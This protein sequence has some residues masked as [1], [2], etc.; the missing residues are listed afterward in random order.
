[1]SLVQVIGHANPTVWELGILT[2]ALLERCSIIPDGSGR[3]PLRR[4]RSVGWRDEM[5]PSCDKQHNSMRIKV[6]WVDLSKMAAHLKNK[7]T[8]QQENNQ[9]QGVVMQ[10]KAK[11]SSQGW[12]LFLIQNITKWFVPLILQQVIH[13][14]NSDSNWT[15]FV[16]NSPPTTRKRSLSFDE[17]STRQLA[18][19]FSTTSSFPTYRVTSH[20]HGW[21]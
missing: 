12:F 20:H 10:P 11:Q 1:M 15:N 18:V 13:S 14:A 7:N 19:V 16:I 21:L 3:G 9:Q 5:L 4:R 2:H 8:Q 17:I 6:T